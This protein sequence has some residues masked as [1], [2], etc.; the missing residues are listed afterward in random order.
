MRQWI[1][2]VSACVLA[3]CSTSQPPP[4][5]QPQIVREAPV[6]LAPARPGTSL[7]DLARASDA[8]AQGIRG[9]VE[10]RVAAGRLESRGDSHLVDQWTRVLTWMRDEDR[11]LRDCTADYW[12]TPLEFMRSSG[13]CEDFSI[14]KF[15]ALRQLG[16]RNEDLRIVVLTDQIRR[17]IHAALAVYVPGEI[18]ILESLSNIIFSH[19]SYG[20]YIPHFSL[21][22]TGVWEH[23]GRTVVPI[24]E[25][26]SEF[27]LLACFAP[28]V[29]GPPA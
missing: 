11:G 9:S 22:E 29:G 16:M 21:N 13:D 7:A 8:Y 10:I 25:G 6:E 27:P 24:A 1:A 4:P 12:A 3:A 18:L 19:R 17:T 26:L 2:F 14:A 23:H 15:M 28:P 20:H 5:P